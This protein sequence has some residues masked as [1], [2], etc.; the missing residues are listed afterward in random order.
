MMSG[1]QCRVDG[2]DYP[3]SLVS[4]ENSIQCPDND[5]GPRSITVTAIGRNGQVLNSYSFLTGSFQSQLGGNT[6]FWANGVYVG[7]GSLNGTFRPIGPNAASFSIDNVAQA[8]GLVG[9]IASAGSSTITE[10]DGVAFQRVGGTSQET[11][12]DHWTPS[13]PGPQ[14]KYLCPPTGNDLANNPDFAQASQAA[15]RQARSSGKYIEA[16]GWILMNRKGALKWQMKATEQRDRGDTVYG[17]GEPQKYVGDLMKRGWTVIADFHTHDY[18]IGNPV[19]V[20]KALQRGVPGIWIFPAGNA[21]AYGPN[22]GLFGR[23]LPKGCS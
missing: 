21:R 5:C 3:C 22:R 6:G 14:N 20:R 7:D 4:G 13:D 9:M 2:I 1:S 17:L 16:G 19:D 10:Y 18:E 23:A 8:I 15:N 11:F 12:S